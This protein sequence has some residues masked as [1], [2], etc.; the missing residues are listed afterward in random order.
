M[1]FRIKSNGTTVKAMSAAEARSR[2]ESGVVLKTSPPKYMMRS[3]VAQVR[4][5][6]IIKAGFFER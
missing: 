4:R 5:M 2:G 1:N 6:I 3:C